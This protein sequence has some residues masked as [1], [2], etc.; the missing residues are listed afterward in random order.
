MLLGCGKSDSGASTAPNGGASV[1]PANSIAA[2]APIRFP[3]AT[4]R[5]GSTIT[6]SP[7]NDILLVADEDHQA[8]RILPLPLAAES[9]ITTI[10]VPGHPAQV[11]MSRNRVLVTLRDLPEGGGA[12][13]I[14]E[15]DGPVGLNEAARIALPTDA[16][17]LAISPDESIALVSS[18]W[19]SK[20]SIVD[21]EKRQVKASLP[22]GR[23]PRG[24]TIL[25]DGKR[26][27][28]SHLTSSSITRIGDLDGSAPTATTLDFPAGLMRAPLESTGASSLGYAVVPNS[29]GDR[30][31]FP[32]HAL[33]TYGGNWFGSSSVD[34]WMPNTDKPLVGKP[35][36]GLEKRKAELGEVPGPTYLNTGSGT[37]VQPRAAIYRARTQTLLVASEGV[38]DLAEFDALM[39]DPSLGFI[40]R[41]EFAVYDNKYIG[42]ATRGGAPSGLALSA[43]EEIAYVHCRST[44]DVVAVRLID[45]PGYYKSVLPPMVHLVDDGEKPADESYALGR[46]L[47][48][49]AHDEMTSGRLGCAGCHPD[50]RD[51]GHVWHE[52]RLKD[53]ETSIVNFMSS[54]ATFSTMSQRV[55]SEG[56]GC[57][58]TAFEPEDFEGTVES[59]TGVGHPRQTPMI[60]GRV[61]AAGPYGWHGESA[62]L[63]KRIAA[64]FTLHRWR[65]PKQTTPEG[66]V[67]RAGH[68]AKFIRAGLKAPK[69]PT[70][71]LNEEEQ[72]GKTIFE[73]S[74]TQCSRCHV[75]ATGFTD[76]TPTPLSQPAVK[77]GFAKEENTAFK[78]PSL[79]NVGGTAP[80]FHD[81]R[82]ATLTD[83]VEKN[84]DK[85]GKTSHLSA[86]D[87][88]ALV[89]YL[90]TL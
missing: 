5:E 76:R 8:L 66:M 84:G 20:V 90:E 3:P 21:L 87:K 74:V 42:V 38:N 83:L 63:A 70:H 41:Y 31:F 23:E 75:P 32:R 77:L 60:A 4:R 16:W 13:M 59:P 22:V 39:S 6:R 65:T 7:Q 17:G 2:N 73:N 19:S 44:D 61:D 25:A 1:A 45:G 47:F 37:F 81:G 10:S 26:A 64:G 52:L 11:I 55:E 79:L 36:P 43:D 57:G 82:F 88:K 14:L 27:Y 12:L 29:Q 67:A 80:Y 53:S 72:K 56:Y 86:E 50:G 62:D 51:D 58:F 40:R 35:P 78:T 49:D 69:K 30:L 9:K 28:V 71:T 24:I 68:L 15:R 85:M 34:V 33:D 48:Y 54:M 46:A 18:A 89:A